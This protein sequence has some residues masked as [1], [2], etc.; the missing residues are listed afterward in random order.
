MGVPTPFPPSLDPPLSLPLEHHFIVG[1]L[2]LI[3][4][5]CPVEDVVEKLCFKPHGRRA[6]QFSPWE[7][8]CLYQNY[9]CPPQR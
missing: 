2:G 7:E 5:G 8:E 9:S 1:T 3:W 6:G 4:N